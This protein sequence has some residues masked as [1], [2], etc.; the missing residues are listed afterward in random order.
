M[1]RLQ[2]PDPVRHGRRASLRGP[3]QLWLTAA[4]AAISGALPLASAMSREEGGT[5]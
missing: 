5:P 3:G 2:R 4:V 1:N